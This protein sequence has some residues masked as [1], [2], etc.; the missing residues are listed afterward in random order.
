MWGQVSFPKNKKCETNPI[1]AVN[2]V[3][4]EVVVRRFHGD[5]GLGWGACEVEK[6]THFDMLGDVVEL[7]FQRSHERH[8]RGASYERKCLR[9]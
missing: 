9:D 4:T 6:R 2:G 7:R 8:D 5:G 3:V 1:W